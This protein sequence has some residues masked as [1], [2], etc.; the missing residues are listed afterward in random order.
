MTAMIVFMVVMVEI[1]GM[2]VA[3]AAC[4]HDRITAVI[5]HHVSGRHP[6][7]PY[8]GDAAGDRAFRDGTWRVF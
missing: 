3:A 8:G 5:D 1:T 2:M 4:G 6:D 7:A